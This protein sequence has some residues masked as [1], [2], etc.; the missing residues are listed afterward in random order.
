M[1]AS[2]VLGAGKG[3]LF[4]EQSSVQG[5]PH[6]ERFHCIYITLLNDEYRPTYLLL[7]QEMPPA[8]KRPA[9]KLTHNTHSHAHTHYSQQE[10]TQAPEGALSLRRHGNR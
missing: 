6:R 10:E 1:Q 4:R 3:A 8:L 9:K 7:L 5:C 2:V